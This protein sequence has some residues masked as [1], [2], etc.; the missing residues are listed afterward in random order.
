MEEK[1]TTFGLAQLAAQ[2][3]APNARPKDA[4]HRAM[5]LWSEA[6][7]EIAEHE[8]R[9][10]YLRSLFRTKDGKEI[11]IFTDTP[12]DWRARLAGY[13]GDA[14]GVVTGILLVRVGCAAQAELAARVLPRLS[15][16]IPVKAKLRQRL[17]NLGG[18]LLLEL[19]PNPLP[20]YLGQAIRGGQLL[21]Q[22][23][24]HLRRRQRAVGF[25]CL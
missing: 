2:A 19:N 4:V 16:A 1:P 14:G 20:D 9:A 8:N 23:G 6:E 18:G 3:A 21:M 7:Q 12:E 11:P 22:K 17:P 5:A 25:P 10:E 13:P 15:L 24:Q